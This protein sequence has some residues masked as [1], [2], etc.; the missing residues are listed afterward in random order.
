MYMYQGKSDGPDQLCVKWDT[1]FNPIRV[2]NF[3]SELT[4]IDT[5][6]AWFPRGNFAYLPLF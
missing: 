5:I 1:W 3:Y 2:N 4:L 6:L